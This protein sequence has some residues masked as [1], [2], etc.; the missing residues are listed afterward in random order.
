M[1]RR[2]SKTLYG[3]E[4][5]D[6]TGCG[7]W[8]PALW[9]SSEHDAVDWV[10]DWGKVSTLVLYPG[11]EDPNQLWIIQNA[12]RAERHIRNKRAGRGRFIT[13][14]TIKRPPPD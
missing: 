1:L 13:V 8:T 7:E 4:H 9:A 3:L 11:Y 6:L 14:E 10:G 2:L 12:E 5:L